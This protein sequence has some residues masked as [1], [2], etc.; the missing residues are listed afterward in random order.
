MSKIYIAVAVAVCIL[1]ITFEVGASTTGS[2]KIEC[3]YTNA[4]APARNISG[5]CQ[6]EYGVIGVTGPAFRRVTWSDGVVTN[7]FVSG[8]EISGE[9]TR[10]KVDGFPSEAS[11]SCGYEVYRIRDNTI[12]LRGD[13]CR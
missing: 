12:E 3:S 5:I 7:I 11:L 1:G 2:K 10:V 13:L 8:S 6:V 4:I 9:R